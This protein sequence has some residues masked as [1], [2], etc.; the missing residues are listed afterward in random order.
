M[1]LRG[2]LTS[3]LVALGLAAVGCAAYPAAP[4]PAGLASITLRPGLPGYAIA[5]AFEGY[6]GKDLTR[7]ELKLYTVAGQT[8]T[9]VML[10]AGLPTERQLGLSLP[11]PGNHFAGAQVTFDNL[12]RDTTYRIKAEA[13]GRNAQNQEVPLHLTDGSCQNDVYVG[14]NDQEVTKDTL[15]RSP[16]VVPVNLVPRVF[17]GRQTSEQGVAITGGAVIP[18]PFTP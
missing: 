13:Y 16:I 10:D 12:K 5:E 7:I 2:A 14:L 17:S 15:N 8:V 3:G 1:L 18:V 9:A 4:G 6:T 11:N